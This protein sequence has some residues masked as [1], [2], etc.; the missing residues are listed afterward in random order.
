MTH[1]D[2]K[3]KVVSGYTITSGN[4]V[5]T[6]DPKDWVFEG[7]LD[8]K[9]WTLL[10]K[11]GDEPLFEKRVQGRSY[12]FEN[13][14]AYKYYRFTFTTH[15][16]T[17]FQFTEIG[18]D[19]VNFSGTKIATPP[20]P[21]SLAEARE[22]GS[23]QSVYLKLPTKTLGNQSPVADLDVFHNKVKPLLAEACVQCHGPK[24]QKGR[25]RVDTLN[26]DLAKG[27][28]MSGWME[29]MNVLLNGEM[30]PEDE[31]V[32]FSDEGRAAVVDWLSNEIQRAAQIARG[33]KAHSSFRRLT[34]YEYNYAL[35]DL[36]GITGNFAE[37]LPPETESEDG[38]KNSSDLL[39][40]TALQFDTFRDIGLKALKRATVTGE[41]P[42]PVTYIISAEEEFDKLVADPKAKVFGL[43]EKDQGKYKNQLHLYNHLTQQGVQLKNGTAKPKE[44][45]IPGQT[46][47]E[48]PVVF[49]MSKGSEL[50]WNLDRFLPDE[51]VMRVSIR[52]WRSNAN[53]EEFAS[54]QLGFSAH[55]SNNANF[56]NI[57]SERNIPITGT[58]EKPQTV[59][60]DIV[61][62]DI[63]RN[64][65]RKLETN[66]PRR[67][68]FLHIS[69]VSHAQGKDPLKVLVGQIEVTAPFYAKWPPQSHSDIF[70]ARKEKADEK[71]YGREVLARFIERAWSR[72]A[73]P[74]ELD[75]FMALL[76]NYRPQ[77]ETFEGAMVEVLATVLA[78]PN[79]LYLGRQDSKEELARK[80][81][82]F[83]WSGIPDEELR[84]LATNG[85]LHDPKILAAQVE[86]M[87]TDPKA[88]RFNKHFVTQWLGLDGLESIAHIKDADLKEAMREEPISFFE[89]LL[90]DN[91]SIL[92]FLHSDYA[93]VNSTLARHYRMTDVNGFG[94]RKVPIEAK[95]NRG[96]LLTSAAV[97]AINSDG[98][99]SHPIKRGV[100]MLERILHDPPPPPPPNVPT[101]D[102]ADP[103]ISKMTLKERIAYHREDPACF[104]CHARIDPWGI[105]FENYDAL[106]NFRTAVKGKPVDASSKL[107][108]K[109]PLV[110]M[111]GL[112]RYLLQERQ[113][114]FAKAMVHKLASYALGRPLSFSDHAAIEELTAQFRKRGDRLGDLVHLLVASDLFQSK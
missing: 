7:S 58:E 57:I 95:H 53:P 87:L 76:A 108:N 98:K 14:T 11:R 64:P 81:S 100:W 34:R 65:F 15:D 22:I 42:K 86:R 29:V 24:K 71:A 61:L 27:V 73:T 47:P 107:F 36:L 38:F 74:Q 85:N 84:N 94:F 75:R 72:P 20:P 40:M 52:A 10:D 109:Q 9:K 77:F 5:P 59:H 49:V 106:G 35:Q 93:V 103:E 80:L 8:A 17:H 78:H 13:K 68:E 21:P 60:F 43:N 96:G 44:N 19:G 30:P 1:L 3:G 26:P 114:Q 2:G 31:D 105:A 67:D 91:A 32:E 39:Q 99:D 41:R 90:E 83:L 56:S 51:G 62:G 55:T 66:F 6:R 112:K 97:L 69:N 110:G 28:D 92:D 70:F 88:K 113:D 48:Y 4:D 12:E 33:E 63:Q 89:K 82:F 25:F 45:A 111:D 50:K 102:L 101:V 46:P 37:R 18:L 104:S 16:T 54:F 23:K 79:F